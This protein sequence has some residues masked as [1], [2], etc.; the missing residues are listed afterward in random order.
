ML[1]VGA[2][3][4]TDRGHH[5]P[6]HV[7]V[8][9]IR[10]CHRAGMLR[11]SLNGCSDAQVVRIHRYLDQSRDKSPLERRTPKFLAELG[12]RSTSIPV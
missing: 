11:V 10:I 12:R 1:G 7:D 8:V 9:E 5:S 4:G 2:L 6:N 3:S